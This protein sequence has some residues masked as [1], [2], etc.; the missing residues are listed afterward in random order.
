MSHGPS[1]LQPQ[2]MAILHSPLNERAAKETLQNKVSEQ[3]VTYKNTM[4]KQSLKMNQNLHPD[5]VTMIHQKV[6]AISQKQSYLTLDK[7][8]QKVLCRKIA[9]ELFLVL[10]DR[11]NHSMQ[12]LVLKI[13][14]YFQLYSLIGA[15]KNGKR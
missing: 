9:D 13:G 2:F 15:I 3:G 6:K 1:T 11:I 10:P 4:K 7:E 14:L 12:V 5:V 8:S